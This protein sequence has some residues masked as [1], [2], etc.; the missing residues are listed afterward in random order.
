MA[1]A[2]SVLA[3]YYPIDRY[4]ARARYVLEELLEGCG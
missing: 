3:R 2:E 4:P 1:D